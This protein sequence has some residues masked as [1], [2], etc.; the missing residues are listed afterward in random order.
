[1]E[2][3]QQLKTDLRALFSKVS[4]DEEQH[5]YTTPQGK[6]YTSVTTLVHTLFPEFDEV[7]VSKRLA[8]IRKKQGIKTSSKKILA[9]WRAIRDNG[10]K[11][12]KQIQAYIESG[13]KPKKPLPHTTSALTFMTEFDLSRDNLLPELL[14]WTDQYNVA[15][16]IDLLE[17]NDDG[18]VSLVDWKTNT[19]IRQDAFNN[20]KG[21]NPLTADIPHCNYW[22]YVLQL[23][24]Y[25]VLIEL[26]TGY[27]VRD[28]TLVH[29]KPDSYFD[30]AIPDYK[31][32]ALE[33]LKQ[34]QKS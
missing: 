21:T 8:I 5:K 14:V 6:T 18:T 31:L 3:T 1:M 30:Y 25:A 17:F 26:E 15:G 22:H 16:T 19:T 27:V 13:K 33:I 34:W 7:A 11:V 29:L 20:E 2:N 28:M 10:T 24:L 23:N 32:I 9:E 12:H 4:L